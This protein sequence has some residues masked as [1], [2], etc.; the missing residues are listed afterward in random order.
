MA[1]FDPEILR[2]RGLNPT[3]AAGSAT[4]RAML[5]LITMR[6]APTPSATLFGH[7]RMNRTDCNMPIRATTVTGRWKAGPYSSSTANGAILCMPG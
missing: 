5:L 3:I 1:D 2:S 4:I 7:R 6:L